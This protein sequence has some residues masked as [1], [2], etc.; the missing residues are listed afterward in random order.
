MIIFIKKS[1]TIIPYISYIWLSCKSISSISP[2]EPRGLPVWSDDGS[3]I[4]CAINR[5][6]W[7]SGIMSN[8][9]ENWRYD[10]NIYDSTGVINN[11]IYSDRHVDGYDAE[12]TK[13]F[14]M[15]KSGYLI[16][17]SNLYGGGGHVIEKYSLN[18]KNTALSVWRREKYYSSDIVDVE[19]IPSIS[20]Q[21]L[22][23]SVY[24]YIN[25][26]YLC[27]YE[28]QFLDSENYEIVGEARSFEFLEH[29][30]IRWVNDSCVQYINA[31]AVYA[32]ALGPFMP[33]NNIA[34]PQYFYPAT[35]SSIYNPRRGFLLWDGKSEKILFSNTITENL[36]RWE[37]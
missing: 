24:K 32:K 15:K 20:G 34:K 16:I 6:D 23:K 37:F 29:V 30:N 33:I 12:V 35:S 3:E 25:N 5:S 27:S 18:G 8:H 17:E 19:I 7:N 2:T 14:Y 31:N 11:I 10:I 26:T 1:Y 36:D 28:V 13:L 22:L 4:A 9:E 21:I